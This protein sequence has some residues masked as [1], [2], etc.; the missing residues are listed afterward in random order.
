MK[1]TRRATIREVARECGLSPGT[2]SNVLN[3]RNELVKPETRDRVLEAV[4]RLNYK[5]TTRTRG[6]RPTLSKNLGLVMFAPRGRMLFSQSFTSHV[7]AGV[8]EEAVNLEWSVTLFMGKMWRDPDA[9]IRQYCYGQCDGLIIASTGYG[10]SLIEPLLERGI[11]FVILG[12]GNGYRNC[13][14]VDIDNSEGARKGTEYLISIGHKRI[15]H[16][17]GNTTRQSAKERAQG[18]L[19]AMSE[20]GLEPQILEGEFNAEAG[21]DLGENWQSFT[22]NY[23][24]TAVLCPND[25]AAVGLQDAL[26]KKGIRCPDDISILGFD[27]FEEARTAAVPLTTIKYPLEL[28]ASQAVRLLVQ[29]CEQSGSPARAHKHPAD[30]VV[31]DSTAPLIR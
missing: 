24:P 30:L 3:S 21:I 23:Q 18:Y 17:T 29:L 8:T 28:I 12:A 10:P 22:G 7:M 4:R 20:A 6:D 11:P 25:V 14:T 2:V 15:L 16:L 31:R 13:H 5:P 26:S 9:A 27:D 19:E 1:E